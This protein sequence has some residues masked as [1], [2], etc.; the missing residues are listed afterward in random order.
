MK[1]T[2]KQE[3]FVQLYLEPG[4][5]GYLNATQAAIGAG[6]SAKSAELIGHQLLKK[7]K[8]AESIS[9]AQ[10]K[11]AR[12]FEITRDRIT[13]EYACMA[14]LD[15]RDIFEDDGSIKLIRDMPESARRALASFDVN[16]IF[17]RADGDQKTAI[18]LA[19]R[20]KFHGKREAL[21]DL[22]EM[23]GFMKGTHDIN[24]NLRFDYDLPGRN[25]E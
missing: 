15:P 5:K 13:Q 12:K 20:V 6:Y 25:K 7:T 2:P 8:V 23:L 11:T 4:Q 21:R 10:A 17:D 9:K 16:E 1:L 22:C 14:F 18:G 19:K 3:R 24:V